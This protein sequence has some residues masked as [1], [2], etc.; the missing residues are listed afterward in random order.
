MPRQRGSIDHIELGRAQAALTE[1]FARE[2]VAEPMVLAERV[3]R[4]LLQAGWRHVR[5]RLEV[6][7][8]DGRPQRAEDAPEYRAAREALRRGGGGQ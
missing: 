1:I 6:D 5:P 3:M 7:L 8:G 4:E 2:H